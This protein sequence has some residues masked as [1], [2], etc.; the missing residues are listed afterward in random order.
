MTQEM[1]QASS[2]SSSLKSSI[3]VPQ[4]SA[5]L[6]FPLTCDQSLPQSLPTSIWPASRPSFPGSEDSVRFP[7]P[8]E[9]A[10]LQ[11]FPPSS[12][13]FMDLFQCL[14]SLH[15]SP[16]R[17]FLKYS[18]AFS[19]YLLQT[20]NKFKMLQINARCEAPFTASIP[21]QG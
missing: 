15:F 6:Y 19:S 13:I 21:L 20:L 1:G 16:S 14:E 2:F 18:W 8:V 17:S 9:A 3:S 7:Y 5:M 10:P 12:V 4:V 11:A